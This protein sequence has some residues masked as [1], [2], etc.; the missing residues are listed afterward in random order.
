M[1]ARSQT[2]L[3]HSRPFPVH[4]LSPQNSTSRFKGFTTAATFAYGDLRREKNMQRHKTDQSRCEEMWCG[5]AVGGMSH[6]TELVQ[7]N[8][9]PQSPALPF[10]VMLESYG[11]LR[12]IEPE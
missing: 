9:T 10:L 6:V 4:T 12:Q 8:C 7:N 5:V 2:R 1:G 3:C 11:I